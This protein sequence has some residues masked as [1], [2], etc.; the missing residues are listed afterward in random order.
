MDL[1]VVVT[2]GGTGVDEDGEKRREQDKTEEV[3]KEDRGREEDTQR[4]II[5]TLVLVW[6]RTST[7]EV[8]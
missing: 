4:V 7:M 8:L 1:Q 5:M 6:I 3:M 2:V